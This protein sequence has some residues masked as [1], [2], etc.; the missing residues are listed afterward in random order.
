MTAEA[1]LDR[2]DAVRPTGPGRW[3]AKCPAHPDRRASLSIREADDDKTLLHCFAGCSVHDVVAAAGVEL[4]DLFPPRTNAHSV[5]GERRPFP[6]A[7]VLRCV[8]FEALVVA[9]AASRLGAGN[10]IDA[11]DRARLLLAAS[12]LQAAA[13][14]SGHAR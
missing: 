5:K 1:L 4:G 12:R 2:L 11:K 14:E 3:I 13:K 8:V 9:T 6:A 10:L 7:D